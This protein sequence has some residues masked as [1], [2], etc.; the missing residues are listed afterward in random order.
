MVSDELIQLVMHFEGFRAR[1]YRDIGGVWTIGYGDTELP[2]RG[3][4]RITQ[5]QARDELIKKLTQHHQVIAVDDEV[6]RTTRREQE[7]TAS[8]AY[9]VGLRRA[10]ES[11]W[12]QSCKQGQPN[13]VLLLRWRMANG[14]Q[15]YGLLRRRVA[16]ALHA[17]GRD[18][19][20]YKKYDTL[21]R[22]VINKEILSIALVNR[23]Y[24]VL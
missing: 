8:L 7:A 4:E 18:W 12:W 3:I 16:E 24:E 23:I 20:D 13:L 5:E 17:I 11:Q 6:K 1:V 21:A 15:V 22:K 2:R 9:N 14:K 19:R 10:I